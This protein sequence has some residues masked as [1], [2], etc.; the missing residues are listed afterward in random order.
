MVELSKSVASSGISGE[1]EG[2]E[3]RV[4]GRRY[5][6]VATRKSNTRSCDI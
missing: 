2:E 3:L 6:V 5:A 1:E 4:F